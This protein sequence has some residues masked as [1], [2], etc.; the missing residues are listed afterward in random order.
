M[1][2]LWSPKSP[3]P[4]G[5]EGREGRDLLSPD[6]RPSSKVGWERSASKGSMERQSSKTIERS[7]TIERKPSGRIAIERSSSLRMNGMTMERQLS[8]LSQLPNLASLKQPFK[9][10]LLRAEFRQKLTSAQVR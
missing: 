4:E 9:I 1:A 6:E 2:E 3:K 5:R 7:V 10:D 8:G